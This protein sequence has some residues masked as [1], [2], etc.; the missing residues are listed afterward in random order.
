ML[1]Q[2][3]F[4]PKTSSCFTS[5]TTFNFEE[6][7]KFYPRNDYSVV[8]DNNWNSNIISNNNSNSI[9]NSN[10]NTSKSSLNNSTSNNNSNLTAKPTFLV[11]N[12]TTEYL[13]ISEIQS[14]FKLN[15]SMEEFFDIETQSEI[16][17]CQGDLCNIATQKTN[18]IVLIFFCSVIFFKNLA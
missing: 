3:F 13:N 7:Q 12:Q 9:N 1:I 17:F 11:L 15:D 14:S 8:E 10:G 4:W 18:S 6:I 2:N 5:N 16:C